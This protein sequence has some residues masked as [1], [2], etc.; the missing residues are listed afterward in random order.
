MVPTIMATAIPI[1]TL[2][3]DFDI[4][5]IQRYGAKRAGSTILWVIWITLVRDASG[6]FSLCRSETISPFSI[7]YE[8][9]VLSLEWQ[10]CS[11][12]QTLHLGLRAMHTCRP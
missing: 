2:L 11:R 8:C 10:S 9:Q 7:C 6:R 4:C 1:F 5:L 12:L 3:E